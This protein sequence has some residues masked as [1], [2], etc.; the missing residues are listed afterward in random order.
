M[1][2]ATEAVCSLRVASGCCA[3]AERQLN[4]NKRLATVTAFMMVRRI[5]PRSFLL[6]IRMSHPCLQSGSPS[7]AHASGTRPPPCLA[8]MDTRDSRARA[9][10]PGP[11]R[12]ETR[13]SAHP[14]ESEARR[15]PRVLVLLR[16]PACLRVPC[17]P[18]LCSVRVRGS[19]CKVHGT[20]CT[21]R[22]TGFPDT[23]GHV[24][25]GAPRTGPSASSPPPRRSEVLD[26][27]ALP[28][29]PRSLSTPR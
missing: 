24:R 17:S 12:R 18:A 4:I 28:H 3:A 16:P 15:G 5:D 8:E 1:P 26:G 22:A 6:F 14:T 10:G 7:P 21:K 19:L 27:R 13:P 20:M 9:R 25:G 2:A 23:E 11:C 29:D